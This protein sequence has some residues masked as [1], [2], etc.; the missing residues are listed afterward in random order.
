MDTD[1]CINNI[2]I[3]R[4]HASIRVPEEALTF[5][6]KD[7][8]SRNGTML[9]GQV[10]TDE[11]Q[12]KEG[13]KVIFGN[14][15]IL[16]ER[17]DKADLLRASTTLADLS[18][19]NYEKSV[20]I[21]IDEALRPLPKKVTDLPNVVESISELAKMIVLPEPKELML[22]RALK[23]VNKLIPAD[24]LAVLI[25]SE[26]EIGVNC[27]ANVM[28]GKEEPGRFHLSKTIINDIL[29]QKTAIVIDD[30]SSNTYFAKQQSIITSRMKSAMAVPLFDEGKVLGILYV[31]SSA[32]VH[33]YNDDSLRLLAI[34]GNI[35]ASKLLNYELLSERQ[36]RRIMDNELNRAAN[37][38][39]HLLVK[40]PPE[41]PQ[42]E[43]YPFLEQS[44]QV[45]GDLYDVA[46]LPDGRLIFMVADVSGKG[47]GASL[48]AAN[49]LASFRIMYH[50]AE[51]DLMRTVRIVS[52]ELLKFS[53]VSDFATLFIGILDSKNHTIKF[54]NAGHNYPILVRND[55]EINYLESSGVAIGAFE[56]IVWKEEKVKAEKGDLLFVFSDGVTEATREDETLYGEE[57]ME[58]LVV[59]NRKKNAEE[60]VR[61]LLADIKKFVEGAPSSDD[62]TMLAL[63]RIE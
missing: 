37:I 63:K 14:V 22:R 7:L 40:S 9:N 52:E 43:I 6:M 8:G 48:L 50:N 34:F 27:I 38:Q 57:R 33:Q 18:E 53:E 26:N 11:V 31:D 49:I 23:L 32:L 58:T 51:L 54:V 55:G 13:D 62:I 59:E 15:E 56:N 10:V 16:V 42:Y 19:E 5:F 30:V 25:T 28:P 45:G 24:R 41:V 47:M 35:I 60:I 20:M 12:I 36:N 17:V 46:L 21:S 61:L 1:F 3:S 44:R 29:T 39:Q 2:T 4:Q